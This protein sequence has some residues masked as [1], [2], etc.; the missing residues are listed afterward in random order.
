MTSLNLYFQNF[1]TKKLEKNLMDLLKISIKAM[2]LLDLPQV[3]LMKLLYVSKFFWRTEIKEKISE[4]LMTSLN[5]YFQNF[6]T[7]KLEKN[8]MDL[9]KISIKAMNLLDLP[10]VKLMKLLD[11]KKFFLVDGDQGKN[12]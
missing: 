2:N 5:L 6:W 11:V 1:W 7:K 9:L 3:K 10:Q 8:L 4:V 12:F